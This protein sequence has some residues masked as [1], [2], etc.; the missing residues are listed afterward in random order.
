VPVAVPEPSHHHLPGWVRR[1]FARVRRPLGLLLAELEGEFA[2]QLRRRLEEVTTAISSGRFSAAWQY[3]EVVA[4]GRRLLAEQRRQR[5]EREHQARVLEGARR[6][7]LERVADVEGL[8]GQE[9]LAR[10]QRAVR[11][12]PDLSTLRS[13]ESDIERVLGQARTA[14]SRRREREIERARAKIR[15]VARG[16][17]GDT[18]RALPWQEVLRRALAETAVG[19]VSGSGPEGAGA[20]G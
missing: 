3:P 13:A 5:A 16:G 4:E 19:G 6:R 7:L 14:W 9:T 11:A 12:A 1:D 18:S 10:L 20:E 15:G 8:V 17:D 2:E